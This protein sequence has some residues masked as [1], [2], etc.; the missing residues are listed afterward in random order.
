MITSSLSVDATSF[1][2]RSLDSFDFLFDLGVY[3]TV[4]HISDDKPYS[5]VLRPNA[6]VDP[7]AATSSNCTPS[8]WRV[9][10]GSKPYL[11]DT[12][13]RC[14]ASRPLNARIHA[15]LLE[16]Y[17]DRP[18]I[19]FLIDNGLRLLS[20]N[21]SLP[22]HCSSNNYVDP[23]YNHLV[24]KQLIDELSKGRIIATNDLE[25]SWKHSIGA[26]YR[27]ES[28]P[29]P[30]V[31]IIHNY[32]G[33]I[34]DKIKYLKFKWATFDSL[35]LLI[36]PN[37]WIARIDVKWYYR[38]F[39]L[40]P[41]DWMLTFFR[42]KFLDDNEIKALY[43]MFC[44]FGLRH[45]GEAAHRYTMGLLYILYCHAIDYV[46]ALMDDFALVHEDYEICNDSYNTAIQLFQYLGLVVSSDPKK[47]HPPHQHCIW[48]GLAIDTKLM[49]ATLRELK[50]NTL[51]E[52][53]ALAMQS[54]SWLV[55]FARTLNGLISWACRV[56]YGGRIYSSEFI[57]IVTLSQHSPR[58]HHVHPRAQLKRQVAWWTAAI[59]SSKFHGTGYIFPNAPMP[60]SFAQTDARTPLTG[61]G[62]IGVF[63]NGFF[64]ALTYQELCA[65]FDDVPPIDARIDCFELFAVLVLL[66][67]FPDHLRGRFIT[68]DIDNPG[69]SK[70]VRSGLSA[71]PELQDIR[72]RIFIESVHVGCRLSSRKVLG[73]EIPMADALSRKDSIKFNF[74][75]RQW[76]DTQQG[77]NVDDFCFDHVL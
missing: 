40:D 62:C 68:V 22:D 27:P 42:W 9:R 74:H 75:Y 34:N 38:F 28:L 4:M 44:N 37:C 59:D 77:L 64:A 50:L 72:E 16:G 65:R 54:S 61:I 53:L 5:G 11:I 63:V 21:D 41:G 14:I 25:K 67:I 23:E 57:S 31:R 15:P 49:T 26:I 56:V 45:A 3:N 12:I 1:V 43:D 24:D 33:A 73:S 46:V 51:R 7:K 2:P 76:F 10:Y 29:E 13:D 36:T 69:A 66:R 55:S 35:A 60:T 6:V 39:P 48:S 20:N 18:F 52:H 70:S 71:S 32:R 58:F 17:H 47:T 8:N 19:L 30:D